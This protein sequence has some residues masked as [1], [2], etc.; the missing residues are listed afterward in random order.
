MSSIF[1]LRSS[2]MLEY[3]WLFALLLISA[4]YFTGVEG[5]WTLLPPISLPSW[6]PKFFNYS[7]N[8]AC[9]YIYTYTHTYI[10]IYIHT[11]THIY[12][13]IRTY[14]YLKLINFTHHRNPYIFK[15]HFSYN[16]CH[17][18]KIYFVISKSREDCKKIYVHIY[19]CVCVSIYECV[20]VS[21][22]SMQVSITDLDFLW[23]INPKAKKFT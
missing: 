12:T 5:K 13:Y 18:S 6:K 10:Y 9:V 3:R 1:G 21:W 4:R 15:T 23:S 16:S 19:K 14:I 7:R 22:T 2:Y 17:F 20:C 11:H 8:S